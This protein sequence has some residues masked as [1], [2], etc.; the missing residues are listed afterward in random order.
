MIARVVLPMLAIALLASRAAADPIVDATVVRRIE[1]IAPDTSRVT[2]EVDRPPIEQYLRAGFGA[3]FQGT[4]VQ[5]IT[6]G[7][8]PGAS[9]LSITVQLSIARR[10]GPIDLRIDGALTGRLTL[11]TAAGNTVELKLLLDSISLGGGATALNGVELVVAHKQVT[12]PEVDGEI[13]RITVVS[14]EPS[15]IALAIEAKE[16]P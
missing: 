6:V 11:A 14:V 3:Q 16:G 10:V 8:N 2:V 12:L 13:Q 15:W 9:T 1:R 4:Q 5:Q 7:G